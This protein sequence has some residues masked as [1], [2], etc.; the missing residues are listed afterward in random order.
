MKN[1]AWQHAAIA[2]LCTFIVYVPPVKAQSNAAEPKLEMPLQAVL[3]PVVPKPAEALNKIPLQP[4]QPGGYLSDSLGTYLTIGGV[5]YDGNGKVES[6]S[7]V[8]ITVDGKRLEEP[9]LIF[10]KHVR[11]PGSQRC[12]LKG[13][14]L[15]A[16][17]GSLPRFVRLSKHG[18]RST[19][20]KVPPHGEGGHSLSFCLPLN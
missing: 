3:P 2:I 16:M 7:L 14:E 12:V 8:V 1:T 10:V 9:V 19:K 17:I 20:S 15:G 18:E 13:Y 6:N 4:R 11:L 5:L